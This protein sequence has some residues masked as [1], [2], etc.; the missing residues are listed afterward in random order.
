VTLDSARS[1]GALLFGDTSGG[2][3]WF[4]NASGGSVLTLAVSSG[5]PTITVANTATINAPLAG[6]AGL[7]KTGNGTL[8]LGGA[9]NYSGTTVVSAGTVS[10][11]APSGTGAATVATP[12]LYM[13]F[14]KMIG[15]TVF[16]EGSGGAIMN[17]SLVGSAKIVSGGRLGGNCLS[18]GSGAPSVGFVQ[19]NNTVVPLTS[20][21]T[22][23]VALWMKTTNAG[24]A[25]MYQGNAGWGSGNMSFYLNPGSGSAG[26]HAGGVSYGQGWEQGSTAINDGTWHFV[27]MTCDG[28]SKAMYV[29]GN[30]DAITT[31]WGGEHRCGQ[32]S[33]DRR[34]L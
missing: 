31:S 1:A 19:V 28:T 33:I 8:V 16:N 9:N 14:D 15:N 18:I 10:Q 26:T 3:N 24:A 34:Q 13:S 7:T 23:T 20:T 12:V 2:Q 25:Y 21:G 30:V 29:D 5:S 17:G 4:L 32:P 6:T 11:A 22:W 27:V